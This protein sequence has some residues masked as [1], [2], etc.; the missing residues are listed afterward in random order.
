[1]FCA[2][3]SR[4]RNF[5]RCAH[6]SFVLSPES[7]HLLLKGKYHCATD[8]LFDWFACVELDR[9]LKVWWNPNQ[10][11]RRS[12]VQRYFPLQSKWV[13]SAQT[14]IMRGQKHYWNWNTRCHKCRN[15]S[16]K[17]LHCASDAGSYEIVENEWLKDPQKW[18]R[19]SHTTLFIT[20][21]VHDTSLSY[22]NLFCICTYAKLT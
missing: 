12:A 9:D 1:M 7:T 19:T 18:R 8:L 2:E 20:I 5:L 10:S 17:A 4:K 15:R 6:T 16:K 11:N 13:F 22:Y 21:L 3:L 14:F